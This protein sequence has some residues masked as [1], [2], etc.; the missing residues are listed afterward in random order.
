MHGRDF[1]PMTPS[2][3]GDPFSG[4]ISSVKCNTAT[5][6]LYV[7]V[8]EFECF[9]VDRYQVSMCNRAAWKNLCWKCRLLN[10]YFLP[11]PN[12]S[13][14]TQLIYGLLF[15]QSLIASFL[16]L[17]DLQLDH[18]H[19]QCQGQPQSYRLFQLIRPLFQARG[20]IDKTIS[21]FQLCT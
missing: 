18:R 21:N 16:R 13:E 8:F 4:Q 9:A 11:G 20:V 3:D 6:N 7:F 15:R 14:C 19:C 10:L 5:W 12:K 1:S 2:M 17:S